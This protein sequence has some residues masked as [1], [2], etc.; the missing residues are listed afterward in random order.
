MKLVNVTVKFQLINP[1]SR[2]IWKI[3]NRHLQTIS[4][5]WIKVVNS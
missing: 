1:L 5:L 2:D 3:I 4:F